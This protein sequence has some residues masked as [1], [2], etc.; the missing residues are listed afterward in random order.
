MVTAMGAY[1]MAGAQSSSATIYSVCS[2]TETAR[3][4]ISYAGSFP[5][6]RLFAGQSLLGNGLDDA[7][8][9]LVDRAVGIDYFEF[10]A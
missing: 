6:G 10:A 9:D 1:S 8:I 7:T 4:Q 5:S 2:T 3:P